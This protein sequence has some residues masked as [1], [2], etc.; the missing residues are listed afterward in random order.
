MNSMSPRMEEWHR[1]EQQRIQ[2]LYELLQPSRD[3]PWFQI[4]CGHSPFGDLDHCDCDHKTGCRRV[5]QVGLLLWYPGSHE[6]WAADGVDTGTLSVE[7]MEGDQKGLDDSRLFSGL[8]PDPERERRVCDWYLRRGESV[9]QDPARETIEIRC[10]SEEC[11][12]WPL[13]V[14]RPRL[15]SA[16]E[17]VLTLI[18]EQPDFSAAYTLS[19][20]DSLV[21]VDLQGLWIADRHARTRGGM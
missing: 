12:R 15:Q 13:R 10:P 16:L 6:W 3:R 7:L 8:E 20:S 5:V 19:V 11:R 21:V 9:P 14:D 2:R 1:A 17:A 18:I 4:V